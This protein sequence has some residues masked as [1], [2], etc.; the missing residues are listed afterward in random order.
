MNKRNRLLP[1]DA[2][3]GIRLGISVSESSDLMRLGLLES[4]FRVALGEIA[5]NSHLKITSPFSKRAKT[6]PL[7][8]N[9]ASL[10]R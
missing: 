7:A 2:L 4:H 8:I 5:P 6:E 3:A 10:D 9:S 1:P